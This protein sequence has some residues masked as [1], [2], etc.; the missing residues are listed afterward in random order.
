MNLEI[1]SDT[2]FDITQSEVQTKSP[3]KMKQSQPAKL[4]FAEERIEKQPSNAN[5]VA[6][7]QEEKT[8]KKS[9]VSKTTTTLERDYI[10]DEKTPRTQIFSDKEIGDRAQ[11]IVVEHLRKKG[12]NVNDSNDENQDNEGFDLLAQKD[13]IT[14]YIEVKGVRRRWESVQMSHQQGL[15][16]F[17]TVQE[18]NGLGKLEYWLCIVEKILNEDQS[19]ISQ[20]RPPLH[21]INLSREK[22]KHVFNK[23]QWEKRKRPDTDF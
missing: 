15:H 21:S 9:E 3:E 13:G 6:K 7:K 20:E 5:K 1:Y 22:P 14:R 17:K 10:L 18:D 12:W 16:F 8:S 4:R 23:G 19:D 11:D 2:D